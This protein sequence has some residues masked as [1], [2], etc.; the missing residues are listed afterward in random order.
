MANIQ[1]VKSLT[2]KARRFYKVA[3]GMLRT[4]R[5]LFDENASNIELL[6]EAKRCAEDEAFLKSR[7]NSRTLQFFHS[8]VEL[9]LKKCRGRRFSIDDKVFAL[10]LLKQSPKCYKVLQ[11]TFA[12]PSRKILVNMLNKVPFKCGINIPILSTLKESILKMKDIDRNC[13]LLFDEMTIE[14]ALQYNVKEDYIIGFEDNGRD[15]QNKFAD[16]AL[17][18]MAKGIARKWKQPV[19]YYFFE[20]GVKAADLQYIIK[21]VIQHLQNIG[22]KVVATVRYC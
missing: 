20:G 3:K 19:A 15:R 18:I 13:C 8:Q 21:E 9:Q 17:V 7:L 22:L 2:P 12:L 1:S 16:H 14:A 4:A 10:S 5:N 6:Q 11:K